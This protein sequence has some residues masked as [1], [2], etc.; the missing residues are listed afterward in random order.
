MPVDQD[1][2]WELKTTGDWKILGQRRTMRLHINQESKGCVGNNVE[3]VRTTDLTSD[4]SED[5]QTT[6][7]CHDAWKA[8]GRRKNYRSPPS[9]N[10]TTPKSD[11]N[12]D[13]VSEYALIAA[14]NSKDDIPCPAGQPVTTSDPHITTIFF[15]EE[16]RQ[17]K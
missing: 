17:F 16:M 13:I 4:F 11:K 3:S 7:S 14:G 6:I 9:S 12:I 15:M 8:L 5:F 10:A 1:V 2:L